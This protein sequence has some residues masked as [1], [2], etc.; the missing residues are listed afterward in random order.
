MYEIPIN[1][2]IILALFLFIIVNMSMTF[3]TGDNP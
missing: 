2:Y 1:Y 3:S